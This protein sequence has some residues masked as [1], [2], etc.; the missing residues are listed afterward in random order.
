M[1]LPDEAELRDALEYVTGTT[2]TSL[3]MEMTHL[4]TA[5]TVSGTA[6]VFHIFASVCDAYRPENPCRY[7]FRCTPEVITVSRA[8]YYGK[9]FIRRGAA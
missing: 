1:K 5:D 2:A 8:E 9:G 4:E 3:L 7:W 6:I